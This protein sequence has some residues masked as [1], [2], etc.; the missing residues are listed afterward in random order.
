[1]FDIDHLYLARYN[2]NEDGGFEFEE[3][4]NEALQNQ[5]L[6]CILTVLKDSRTPNIGFKS[7]DNDTSLVES[8]AAEIPEEGNTKSV[9][10]N[11]GTLHEQVT[12]KNDYITGKIGIGP[13]ALNVT[14]HIL[15]TLYGVKFKENSFTALT[16]I[17]GFDKVLDKKDNQISSWLSA[18]INAHVDIVKDP[19]IS[20]LNVNSFTYN[21]INLLAR[22]GKGE[23][24]LYFL[25]QPII[26]QMAKA[27]NDAKSQF[28]RN[29][30]IYRSAF[31]M[32]SQIIENV[33]PD[34]CGI[35]V[36]DDAIKAVI[37]DASAGSLTRKAQIVNDVLNNIDM[38]QRI[39]KDPNGFGKTDEAKAFQ[40][41]CY[42]AWM[43]LD[44]YANA[45]NHLVQYTKI[46]TR[47]QGKNFIEMQ[48][49]LNN[50][51]DLVNPTNPEESIFNMDT[52]YDLVDLSWIDQKTKAAIYYPIDVMRGQSFQ[53]TNEFNIKVG[54]IAFD[55]SMS[56]KGKDR[57]LYTN[58]KAMRKIS[59][60]CS[61][62]IKTKYFIELADRLGIDTKGLFEGN[63]TI[64][65]RL[66]MLQACITRDLGGLSRLKDNY[67]LRHLAPYLTDPNVFNAGKLVQKPK[68]LQVLNSMDDSKMSA[69]MFIEA[70]EELLNDSVKNVRNFARDLIFYAM[71]TSGDTKGFNKLGKYVPISYLTQ[72]PL[73]EFSSFTD[74]ISS[75]LQHPEID[76]DAI[77]QNN[78]MDSD[79]IGRAT[80]NDF[81]YANTGFNRPSVLIS[82]EIKSTEEAPLYV[83]VRYKCSKYNDVT[84]YNLY[85]RVG[86]VLVEGDVKQV[87][88]MLPKKGWTEKAG[89]SI[90][91]YGDIGLSV[92]STSVTENSVR[93]QLEALDKFL[94]EIQPSFTERDIIGELK[95]YDLAYTTPH[96]QMLVEPADPEKV[97]ALV[98]DSGTSK[99]G[100]TVYI[101]RQYYYK[102]Q[103]QKHPNVQYV[104]T[105]NYQ[106]AAAVHGWRLDGSYFQHP[107]LNVGSG[108]NGTNQACIR[109]DGNGN[110]SHNA[111]GLIVKA[112][113][114]DA[115]GRFVNNTTACIANS[116]EWIQAFK[117]INDYILRSIDKNKPV[118][119]PATIA[120]GKA[121]L[122]M[123]CAKWLR[124]ELLDRY[125]IVSEVEPNLNPGYIGTYGVEIKG[126]TST[127]E[128]QKLQAEEIQK[129]ALAQAGFNEQDMQQAKDI[130]NHCK[131]GK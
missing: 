77:A 95:N 21:M 72:K 104:F 107:K 65:D 102:G 10:F 40:V 12:R 39:A 94:R 120:L 73:D 46:D 81:W 61:T 88:A 103:P 128:A 53:G 83:A 18:F 87:Y 100:Q 85:K 30:H 127:E 115:Q 20:K 122:P 111:Y 9:A 76:I 131:G 17:T 123:E 63:H 89:L 116:P 78:M 82:K 2:I 48:N 42:E 101:S 75:Q 113:Q 38:L 6:D 71:F 86:T 23:A 29:P 8:I 74:Y 59:Q 5:I 99:D 126:V 125:N 15:T 67:L 57:R 34:V 93:T 105:E 24:G 62:A 3:G 28:T 7:I 31:D 118:V 80:Y 121:G 97:K 19:Y 41:K 91:E 25:C 35:G 44:K 110:L 13:F 47:K 109:T 69:D 37:E 92:N 33:F 119:F 45:L 106:A 50:Y 130:T 60:A 4:S 66:N 55:L 117:N 1:M 11:F 79:L 124:K 112:F 32:R 26:R 14:N 98:K 90:Y 114:Q 27:D 36:N 64:F 96:K 129:Q 70:W 54:D 108:K 68:F 58:S 16:G 84:S 49:Y 43:V 22:N 51:N 56:I 52:I